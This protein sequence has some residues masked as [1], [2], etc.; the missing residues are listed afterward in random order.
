MN[1][2]LAIAKHRLASGETLVRVTV[3]SVKG[4]APRGPGAL[5]L[6][7]AQSQ[8]GSIGGGHLEF[9]ASNIARDLLRAPTEGNRLTRFALGATLGQCCGGSVELWFERLGQEDLPFLEAAIAARIAR[10]ALVIATPV[11]H[12]VANE[13]RR[14][15]RLDELGAEAARLSAPQVRSALVG[16]MLYERIDRESSDLWLFG[17]GHVGKAL[18]P[19]LGDLPF[20]VTWVDTREA[21]FPEQV[22]SNVRVLACDDAAAE[23]AAAAGNARFLVMTH[24]HDLDF[25]IC[26]AILDRKEF[27]WAGLIGSATKAARFRA[28]LADRGYAAADIARITCPIGVEGIRGKWPSVIA[29][30]VA[31]QLLRVSEAAHQEAQSPLISRTPGRT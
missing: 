17:A 13:G 29:V 28:R 23:V 9:L 19:I 16:G 20:D 31:A 26:R 14:L 3:A 7:G 21:M 6:V 10:P 5:M 25:D 27:A 18:I 15:I 22:P 12:A 11:A 30:S 4:S 8:D 2:W 1:D 24:S